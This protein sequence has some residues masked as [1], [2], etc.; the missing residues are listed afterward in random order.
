MPP[1]IYAPVNPAVV[2]WARTEAG[3]HLDEAARKLRVAPDRVSSWENGNRELT[4]GQVR[5][6]GDL[7][8]RTPAF[9]FLPQPPKESL[10]DLHIH[11]CRPEDLTR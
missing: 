5:R 1:R 8:G 7:Y 4:M 10:D 3:L 6:M 9:F 2:R 11:I